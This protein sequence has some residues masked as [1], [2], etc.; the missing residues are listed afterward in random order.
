[1]SYIQKLDTKNSIYIELL[2]RIH[3]D[4]TQLIN[5]LRVIIRLHEIDG[6]KNNFLYWELKSIME[7]FE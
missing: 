1:M 5:H 2:D 4:I 7:E 6:Q 3:M